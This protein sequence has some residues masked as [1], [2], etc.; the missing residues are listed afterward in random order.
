MQANRRLLIVLEVL[1]LLKL[2][3]HALFLPVFEGPD[4]PFH[5]A[6]AELFAAGDWRE[7]LR[8]EVV[9]E[10]IVAAVEVGPCAPDLQRAFGC[11]SFEASLPAWFNVLEQRTA[12]T[13]AR[14]PEVENYQAHQPPLYYLVA[15]GWLWL[16][17]VE[18][19]EAGLLALR[20]LAVA[21]VSAGAHLLRRTLPDRA[22]VLALLL[23]LLPGA[24]ESLVRAA[25]DV[26]VFAWSA[27]VVWLVARRRSPVLRAVA[28]AAG[29]FWK[30]TAFPVVVYAV[31][32]DW[33]RGERRTAVAAAVGAALVLP[34][35]AL[36]GWAWGGTLELN[37]TGELADSW[38]RIALGIAHSV[39]TFLKTAVWLGGWS[40][41]R[42]P[43][44]LLVLGGALALLWVSRLRLRRGTGP[45]P[46]HALA[47]VVA[48]VG[49]ILFAVGKR[50][51]FG[52]WGAVG[53]WYL[54]G[55]YPW[56]CLLA[57]Q[58]LEIREH[59]LARP[60]AQMATVAF[61]VLA[62]VAWWWAAVHV[63]G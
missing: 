39:Y 10:R 28:V 41:F 56:L 54:W 53:G 29:P 6:R 17:R 2:L 14:S 26:A 8:G 25:N 49:F 62:N 1:L 45:M 42:P 57:A 59:E 34:Y 4:E 38:S 3:L 60:V 16:F 63:Y 11:T 44:W 52:V 23:L 46:P 50:Q 43:I 21:L 13:A 20:L 7:A 27:L 12:G 51:V 22:T 32:A 58:L 33:W 18:T 55:W 36:R 37:A 9:P 61:V 19:P 40:V 35:Q 24:A 30:L 15:G 48:A 5:L 31:A 47:L